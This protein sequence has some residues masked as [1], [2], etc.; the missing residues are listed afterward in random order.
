MAWPVAFAAMSDSTTSAGPPSMAFSFSGAPASRKS[1]LHEIDAGDRLHRQEI[2]G[3]DAARLRRADALGRHLAP[4]AGRG[5]EIDHARAFLEEARLVVDLDQ[6][7]GGAR[8]NAFALGARDVRIVELALQPQ[9][10]RQLAALAR[11]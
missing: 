5:A 2:D 8:A 10:G 9:L 4:A 3:D 1:S 11:S 7:V 6:L